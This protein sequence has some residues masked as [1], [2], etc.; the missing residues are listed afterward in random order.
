M[1]ELKIGNFNKGKTEDS[2]P[3][4]PFKKRVIE[5]YFDGKSKFS[6]NG[7]IEYINGVR[8]RDDVGVFNRVKIHTKLM[9]KAILESLPKDHKR[10]EQTPFLKNLLENM[11]HLSLVTT[12]D[13]SEKGDWIANPD[14]DLAHVDEVRSRD[15]DEEE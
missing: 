9:E 6:D 8:P 13:E 15:L 11:S 2:E 10:K 7:V 12:I 14:E 1:G 3:I 4:S 5:G